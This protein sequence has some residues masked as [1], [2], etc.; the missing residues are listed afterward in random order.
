MQADAT[1]SLTDHGIPQPSTALILPTKGK[2]KRPGTKTAPATVGG[3]FTFKPQ[4]NATSKKLLAT[5]GL[6]GDFLARQKLYLMK[7]QQKS[8]AQLEEMKRAQAGTKKKVRGA[9]PRLLG[10]AQLHPDTAATTSNSSSSGDEASDGA[11]PALPTLATLTDSHSTPSTPTRRRAS[12]TADDDDGAISHSPRPPSARRPSTGGKK[13][14][15]S[16]SMNDAQSVGAIRQ[17]K[18][19]CSCTSI[20]CPHPSHLADYKPVRKKVI[21]IDAQRRKHMEKCR[22]IRE[23]VEVS[24]KKKEIF[25]IYGGPEA[26]PAVRAGLL[27][28]GWVER[29]PP[30]EGDVETIHMSANGCKVLRKKKKRADAE[31]TGRPG[32]HN[33]NGKAAGGAGSGAGAAAAAAAAGDSDDDSDDDDTDDD[34]DDGDD[35]GTTD[36]NERS[37]QLIAERLADGAYA[38]DPDTVATI[39]AEFSPNFIWSPKHGRDIDRSTLLDSQMLNGFKRTGCLTTKAGLTKSCKNLGIY[40]DAD[41]D[42]MYPICYNLSIELER[43]E[44]VEHFI[45]MSA[46]TVL[47]KGAAW[48]PHPNVFEIALSVVE[49]H[50]RERRHE[51]LDEEDEEDGTLPYTPAQA[52]ALLAFAYMKLGDGFDKVALPPVPPPRRT[53]HVVAK[54]RSSPTPT[55][56]QRDRGIGEPTSP[57]RSPKKGGGG[58][59]DDDDDEEDESSG[60]SSSSSSCCLYN[61]EFRCNAEA[62]I[63]LLD[64][65][66]GSAPPPLS[67]EL[68]ARAKE[69]L[70]GVHE[71]NPQ[72]ANGVEGERNVWVVKPAAKSRGRGIFCEN[73]LDLILETV[74]NA[75]IKEKYVAQKYIESPMQIHGTKFDIRQYF[76]VASWNPLTVYFYKDCYL[77]FS[78]TPFDLTDLRSDEATYRHLCNN[79]IQHN[80][81]KFGQDAWNEAC[82]WDSDQ[83][84]DYLEKEGKPDAWKDLI[85]PQMMDIAVKISK[86]CQE[87]VIQRKNTFELFGADFILDE[88]MRPWCIEVNSSPSMDTSTPATAKVV[89]SALS[90]MLKLVVDRKRDKKAEIGSWELAYKQQALKSNLYVQPMEVEGLEI[91]APRKAN[92]G[93]RVYVPKAP[94]RAARPRQDINE[95]PCDCTNLSCLHPSHR[96]PQWRTS[97]SKALKQQQQQ[98]SQ[99]ERNGAVSPT[100]VTICSPS[101]HAPQTPNTIMRQ[102]HNQQASQPKY[103]MPYAQAAAAA[104]AAAVAEHRRQYDQL[105]GSLHRPLP[106]N[107]HSKSPSKKA[108]YVQ[109]P[110]V[111]GSRNVMDVMPYELMSQHGNSRTPKSQRRLYSDATTNHHHASHRMIVERPS[112]SFQVNGRSPRGNHLTHGQV[113]AA[114]DQRIAAHKAGR[115]SI[116]PPARRGAVPLKTK[117]FSFGGRKR[118]GVTAN[119]LVT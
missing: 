109:R 54:Q 2:K 30:R 112:Q 1:Q 53:L 72:S 93:A 111:G 23:L 48:A 106:I 74:S 82:M 28:R 91:K 76:I 58:G 77:R 80:G 45:R 10:R 14:A 22:E 115:S 79:S 29:P 107:S 20:S 25:T 38:D 26:L 86:C 55:P 71:F 78:S 92:T 33:N 31:N 57:I 84:K 39:L 83:F 56:A 96:N 100:T 49:S 118:G 73:R 113:T 103:Q 116:I 102:R 18:G 97:M 16:L 98:Q 90:D 68:L 70:A 12:S 108:G 34:D 40:E 105:E 37:K 62:G 59:G 44:F 50:V 65:L 13:T 7:R 104:A 119:V 17:K 51:D 99:S 60:N 6:V 87:E 88:N 41:P 24:A 85:Y 11:G 9:N 95:R 110:A 19:M 32:A 36:L 27:E 52:H 43:Q 3:M 46:C 21:Q 101:R 75:D 66:M 4:V 89:G 64:G 5:T 81:D 42:D 69:G 8:A 15:R 67:P 117:T 63:A 61:E 114:L 94:E 47:A 35:D